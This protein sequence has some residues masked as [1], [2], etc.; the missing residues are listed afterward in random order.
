MKR[1]IYIENEIIEILKN[2][3][4]NIKYN[5]NSRI[6]YFFLQEYMKNNILN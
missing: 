2:N 1:Y 4:K 5:I 6:F 3:I